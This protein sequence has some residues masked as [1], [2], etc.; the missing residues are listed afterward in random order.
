MG[1]R[2]LRRFTVADGM[3]LV[4]A[5]GVAA[6]VVRDYL[7]R[8]EFLGMIN[9]G[10]YLPKPWMRWVNGSIPVAGALSSALL[11]CR[12]LS[13]RPRRRRLWLL[14][15]MTPPLAVTLGS[16]QVFAESAYKAVVDW[17]Q[18]P[19]RGAGGMTYPYFLN[20]FEVHCQAVADFVGFAVVTN[21][22][23]LALGGRWR[24]E[25]SWVDRLGRAL[26]VYWI[27]LF[28]LFRWQHVLDIP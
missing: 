19:R 24:A 13:P 2:S 18:A 16:A 11:I 7:E 23:V 26:G 20:Q 25:R 21:W 27:A 10:R 4:A 5:A 12:F 28:F 1:S 22:L 17:Q 8:L 15:G 3:I 14:P 9:M 6:M